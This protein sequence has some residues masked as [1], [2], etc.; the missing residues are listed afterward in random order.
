[1]DVLKFTFMGILDGRVSHE[2]YNTHSM[3]VRR[4]Y[5]EDSSDYG[6]Y[7]ALGTRVQESWLGPIGFWQFANDMGVRPEG[8]T[9]D[10]IDPYGDY[11]KHNCRWADKRTQ[12]NNTRNEG[13]GALKVKG[14]H[15]C[16]RDKTL[17]VQTSL[18]KK[19]TVIGRFSLGEEELAGSLYMDVKALKLTGVSDADIYEKYVLAQRVGLGKTKKRRNKT[20]EYWG[21]SFRNSDGKWCASTDYY[22][23]IFDTEDLARECVENWLRL[24]REGCSGP[25][26]E[27]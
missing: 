10:R 15:W 2:L 22:L 21:V 7:G 17:I 8:M 1:M 16:E 27:L 13:R 14:V 19:R 5:D 9:L 26:S 24:N 23:G 12:A 4:C 11:T 3:M 20:S 6:N 25:T 18:F